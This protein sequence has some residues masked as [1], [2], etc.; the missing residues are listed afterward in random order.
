MSKPPAIIAHRGHALK[1]PE[2]T[3]IAFEAAIAAG[4]RFL[5]CDV[6]L[7]AD[8]VPVLCHDSNLKRLCGRQG[9]VH[10]STLAELRQLRA[11]YPSRFGGRFAGNP[12]AT[13]ADFVALLLR[14]PG[15][16]GF[17]EI[18]KAS[19]KQFGVTPVVRTVAA[20]LQPVKAQ[21]V[22][23]SFSRK[24]LLA[25]REHGWP[26]V[27]AV[28][29]SW[30]QR[31]GRAEGSLR[32]DYLFC[33]AKGLPPSGMLSMPGTKIAV[34]EVGEASQ[35]LALGE[36]GVDLVETFA[37]AELISELTGSSRGRFTGRGDSRF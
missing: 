25:A 16:T 22:I 6:Q 26:Q 19:L 7:S 8:L 1:F 32:P 13:L 15:V 33:D 5:E 37:V 30:P 14:H 2:N 18:K 31:T 23:I 9:A 29:K 12:L 21:A 28:V 34:F 20:L 3:I 35:A 4:A 11:S 27:G 10:R 17:V 36:R 24:A